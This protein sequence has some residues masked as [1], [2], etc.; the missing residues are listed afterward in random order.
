MGNL[1]KKSKKESECDFNTYLYTVFSLVSDPISPVPLRTLDKH[2]VELQQN[3]TRQVKSMASKPLISIAK[4]LNKTTQEPRLGA[5]AQQ[6]TKEYV[7][8]R[9]AKNI[10]NVEQKSNIEKDVLNITWSLTKLRVSR[11][12]NFE[13]GITACVICQQT[14]TLTENYHRHL[15]TCAFVQPTKSADQ[16]VFGVR[17]N[18]VPGCTTKFSLVVSNNCAAVLVLRSI[19]IIDKNGKQIPVF[20]GTE[21]LRM[22]PDYCFEEIIS[23][24]TMISNVQLIQGIQYS[25]VIMASSLGGEKHIEIVEIHRLK[26]FNGATKKQKTPLKLVKLPS[27][28]I[29]VAIKA[30]YKNNF[31]NEGALESHEIRILTDVEG[32]K[33]ATSLTSASY[34]SQLRLLNQIE[35]CHLRDEFNSYTIIDPKLVQ[36]GKNLYTI[37]IN[38]FKNRP[39]LIKENIEVLISV[40]KGHR[41]QTLI[42]IVDRVDTKWIVILMDRQLPIEKVSKVRF[43]QNVTTFQMEYRALEL[44]DDGVIDKVLFPQ[45]TLKNVTLMYTSFQWFS[46]SIATNKEQM[47]AVRNIVN[48]TSF[49]APYLLFGPPGTGK[50]TTLVEAIA[51]IYKLCPMANILVAASSNFA[52]NELTGR[53]LKAVPDE[54][55]F[56][57]FSRSIERKLN[58]VN[59]DVVKVSNMISGSYDMPYYEDIYQSRIVVCTL[60]TA[61]RLVQA[62]IVKNHFTYIFIDEAGSA[63]EISTL[64]PIIGLAINEETIHASI[65]LAGDPK[66]LGP[67]IQYDY[68]N[69][70]THSVS[71]MERMLNF[72]EMY[73]KTPS[74]GK[75]NSYFITQL[76]DNFRSAKALL[77]LPNN[78]FYEGQLRAKA[79]PDVAHWA[80]HWHR[81]PNRQFPIILHPVIGELVQDQNTSSYYNKLEAEQVVFYIQDILSDGINNKQ[82]KQKDIGVISPYAR[83]VSYLKECFQEH[84]WDDIEVGSTEQY[85]GREKLIII[86]STV[87]SNCYTIGFLGNVKRLNVTITRARAL[88]IIVCNPVTLARNKHWKQLVEYCRKNNAIAATEKSQFKNM[89]KK[90]RADKKRKD[91]SENN[92]LNVNRNSQTL[93]S[94][95]L[96]LTS[97]LLEREMEKLT[98]DNGKQK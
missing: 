53:L 95:K 89:R 6:K 21:V 42:G 16:Q 81:L 98:I 86:I 12:N 44:L 57:F 1:F 68:L 11:S 2:K 73:R 26:Q 74:N 34:K 14:F 62:N 36:K 23:L 49:P 84:G 38:Q 4:N 82:V 13:G 93:D 91:P 22:V 58:E 80:F 97:N 40:D 76:C 24:D 39:S 64:V 30:L 5:K 20:C 75:F 3:A 79:T 56:R 78:M 45:N 88:M 92:N 61:G 60:T 51:Q 47:T 43:L 67:V 83:Q 96:H 85:Q 46:S 17:M 37:P 52:A 69:Q 90:Y 15:S 28:E 48:R 32:S 50:T 18:F 7:K 65:I 72:E 87:R 35:E 41:D 71:M 9:N 33:I 27:Y 31:K 29:P 66:Q 10:S 8:R 59:G 19:T 94:F 54:S 70:T 63:K 55:I 77:D 25:L